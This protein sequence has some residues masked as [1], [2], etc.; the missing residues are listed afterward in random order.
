MKTGFC[1]FNMSYLK[2]NRVIFHLEN[3]NENGCFEMWRLY[4]ALRVKVEWG[5]LVP[6]MVDISLCPGQVEVPRR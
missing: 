6:S 1:G 3:F 5:E 4:L 2:R